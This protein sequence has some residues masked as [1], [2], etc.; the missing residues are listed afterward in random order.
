[1]IAHPGRICLEHSNDKNRCGQIFP[2][3]LLQFL[4]PLHPEA[5]FPQISGYIAHHLTVGGAGVVLHA[6]V[7][8]AELALF[9]EAAAQ[10]PKLWN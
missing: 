4:G 7:M 8:A 10:V 5:V 1:M 6:Q 9:G 3:F 2:Q